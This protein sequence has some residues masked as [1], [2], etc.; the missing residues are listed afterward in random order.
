LARPTHR[1]YSATTAQHCLLVAK[2]RDVRPPSLCEFTP[3]SDTGA[4]DLA[5]DTDDEPTGIEVWVTPSVKPA[6]AADGDF[7]WARPETQ[8]H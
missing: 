6:L 4:G 3:E 7:V 8:F 2:I 5:S 1:E